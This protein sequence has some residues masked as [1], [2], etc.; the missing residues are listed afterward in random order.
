MS[1]RQFEEDKVYLQTADGNIW[2]YEA[3]L[4]RRADVKK[5]IPNPSKKSESTVET[6]TDDNNE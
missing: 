1:D 3:L 6:E 2:E 5:V 4:A